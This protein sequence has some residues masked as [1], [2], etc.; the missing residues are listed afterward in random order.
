MSKTGKTGL[1]IERSQLRTLRTLG[2]APV[3]EHI[4]L[5]SALEKTSNKKKKIRDDSYS[6]VD[7]V[8]FKRY[9]SS[10]I[11]NVP[12]NGTILKK[13]AKAYAKVLGATKS[14]ASGG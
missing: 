12:I 7:R 10:R 3:I 8:M 14:K 6:E 1:D 9:V 13:K 2:S 11:R 4:E 5:F